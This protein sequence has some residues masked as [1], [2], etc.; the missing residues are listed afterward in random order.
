MAGIKTEQLLNCALCPNICRCECPIDRTVGREKVSPAGKARLAAMIERNQLDWNEDLLEAVSSCLGCRACK[1]LCPFPDL[2]LCDELEQVVNKAGL[3]GLSLRNTDPYLSNLKKYSSPYGFKKKHNIHSMQKAKIVY[4]TGCTAQANNPE[5]I[6]A[7]RALLEEA[8][9]SYTMI[10]EDCCGYPAAIWGDTLL[11]KQLAA[12]TIS[13]LDKT[14]A[15]VLLT[16][17]PECW[18]TFTERYPAWGQVVKQRIMDLPTFLLQLVENEQLK[19]IK[20]IFSAISYHDPCIWSR[21]ANKT[22]VPRKLLKAIPGLTMVEPHSFGE[23][24]RCCG[25][26]QMHQLSFPSISEAIAN[27]RLND[28]PVDL[29]IITSCPFCYEGLKSDQ[30]QV[31]ELSVALMNACDLKPI[32]D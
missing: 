32:S 8:K 12:E 9:V 14:G 16:E 5:S 24:T 27:E 30:R 15:T 21:V 22:E 3:E 18:Q 29:P 1:T 11:A 4:F 17:C 31:I 23:N 7:T 10:E 2:T 28:F 25:G 26:G 19:P 6:A 13:K 20:P